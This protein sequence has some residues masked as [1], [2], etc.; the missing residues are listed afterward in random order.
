MISH[1][2]VA[3]VRK[4]NT[5]FCRFHVLT[6][7]SIQTSAETKH[8]LELNSSRNLS[9]ESLFKEPCEKYLQPQLCKRPRG[10]AHVD[11]A[12][13]SLRRLREPGLGGACAAGLGAVAVGA[14][15]PAPLLWG[16]AAKEGA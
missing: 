1:F 4:R 8:F 12:L 16:N 5:E 3:Q 14:R 6:T 7:G 15:N 13:Q 9:R 11:W 10:A 2:L